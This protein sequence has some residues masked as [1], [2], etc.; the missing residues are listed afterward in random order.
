MVIFL[1]GAVPLSFAIVAF[2]YTRSEFSVTDLGQYAARGFFSFLVSFVVYLLLRPIV[3]LNY[4]LGGIYGY[5]LAH[6]NL[7][8]L[9]WCVISYLIYYQIPHTDSPADESILMLGFFAA[10]YTLLA[11]GE[12]LLNIK[13]ITPYI[14]FLLPISRIGV[15]FLSVGALL[16]A[17][18]M[19]MLIR[20]G[21]ILV[22]FAASGV[23][24]FVPTLYTLRHVTAAVMLSLSLLLIGVLLYLLADRK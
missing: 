13:E 1:A 17:R 2:G 21:L 22:P 4:S 16:F 11:I 9:A 14:L 6:H 19:Y 10:F 7:Y 23:A 24:A 15:I 3:Q 12:I 8:F 20:Y 5:Y 18:R